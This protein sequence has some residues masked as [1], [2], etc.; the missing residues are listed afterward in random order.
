MYVIVSD[1]NSEML[2]G[3]PFAKDLEA[4][5]IKALQKSQTLK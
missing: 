1:A 3:S 4:V 5:I 2:V